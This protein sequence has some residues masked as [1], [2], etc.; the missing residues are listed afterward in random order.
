M[1]YSSKV[2]AFAFTAKLKILTW[3]SKSTSF[4]K[5]RY[6]K[7][8]LLGLTKWPFIWL[9]ICAVITY[10]YQY[11]S[12]GFVAYAHLYPLASIR[13]IYDFVHMNSRYRIGKHHLGCP[14][15]SNSWY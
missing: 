15:N 10:G 3:T 2:S 6:L 7:V 12:L 11:P 13:F 4:L 5:S 9:G 14:N 1:I 8:T